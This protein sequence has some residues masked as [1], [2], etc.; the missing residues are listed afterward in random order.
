[1]L[2]C[3]LRM[4]ASSPTKNNFLTHFHTFQQQGRERPKQG[5]A[6]PGLRR[7]GRESNDAVSRLLTQTLRIVSLDK[8]GR[9]PKAEQ[10]P[11]R[12]GWPRLATGDLAEFMQSW[13]AW[14]PLP[15]ASP[16]M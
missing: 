15:E 9:P 1:M 2:E 10:K 8:R 16:R 14:E 4:T 12:P 5:Y 11:F 13:T 3:F 6:S 7:L